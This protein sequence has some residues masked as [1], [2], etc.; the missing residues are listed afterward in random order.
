MW[1]QPLSHLLLTVAMLSQA[2]GPATKP[3]ALP[4]PVAMRQ[5]TFAIPYQLD[6]TEDSRQPVE[7]QLYVSVDRGAHWQFYAKAPTTQP[8]FPF[9]AGGDGEFWFAIRT[10]DRSGQARP[11]SIAGPGLRVLV[12][13]KP[14]VVRVSAQQQQDGQVSVRLEIDELN[15][16]P[17]GITVTYRSSPT[18]SWQAVPVNPG[19]LAS[20]AGRQVGEVTFWPKLGSSDLEIRAEVLDVA[21]NSA[22]GQTRVRLGAS[23]SQRQPSPPDLGRT[24]ANDGGAAAPSNKLPTGGTSATNSDPRGSVAIAIN[25]AIGN[26]Y[27]GTDGGP[28]LGGTAA[29]GLPPGER[30][31]WVNSRLFELEYDVDSVGPSGIGRVELWGTRDGGKT[32]RNFPLGG[33]RRSPLLVNVEEEGIYGFRIVVTNGAGL[34]AKP[35]RAGDLPDLWIGVDLSKPTARI[36]ATQQGSDAEAGHLVITWQADDRML[37]ARP[38]SLSFAETR[39]GPWLPIASGLENTGRYAWALDSRLPPRIYLRLEVRDEA[40]NVG[41]HELAEPILIDQSR[42]RIRIRD[43]RPLSQTG[44]RATLRR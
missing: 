21:G 18:D 15:P 16:K 43:V 34:G 26:R 27:P 5:A 44:A 8:N 13:T 33:S 23:G 12:D 35:P 9:R 17:N 6:R 7:V 38:V 30:P 3:P 14:P 40:G 41:V 24:A 32:W 39:A 36:V 1:L 4:Q 28:A 25:P 20:T 22:A 42:P 10:I 37:A 11:T 31:R 29:S 2:G 19:T